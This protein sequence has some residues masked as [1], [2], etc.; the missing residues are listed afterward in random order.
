M[1]LYNTLSAEER[2]KLIDDAGLHRLTNCRNEGC[3]LLFIQCDECSQK[4]NGCC[5]ETCK[6][7]VSLP[8][9][10]KK[11]LRKGIKNDAMIYKKGRSEN[12]LFKSNI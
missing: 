10:Q 9:K 12:I 2:A 1:Q 3:H 8:D 7:I 5:C 6:D 11:S 4:M